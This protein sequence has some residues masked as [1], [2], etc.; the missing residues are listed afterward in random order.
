MKR[1]LFTA[2]ICHLTL[3]SLTGQQSAP[4]VGVAQPVVPVT[5]GFSAHPGDD[6]IRG[7]QLFQEMLTP[8][9]GPA[10]E[11]ENED[12]AAALLVFAERT[13]HEDISMFTAFMQQHPSSRWNAALLLNL[14]FERYER[15]YLTQALQYWENAWNLAKAETDEQRKLVADR[16]VGEILLLNAR[17][18]RVPVLEEYLAA[19]ELR[20]YDGSIGAQVDAARQGLAR[21][22]TQPE[23]AFKCGPYA[24]NSILN[25]Q[26][27]TPNAS[28]AQLEAVHSTSQGTNLLQVKNWAAEVG[29]NYQ[30]ARRGE[31]AAYVYPAVLHWKLDHFAALLGQ[32]DGRYLVQDATFNGAEMWI[33]EKALEAET[34][35]YYLIRSGPLPEGW[36]AVSDEQAAQI[37]GKGGASGRDDDAKNSCSS[38]TGNPTCQGGAG[39]AG[40]NYY[41]MHATLNI[42]DTPMYH[43]PP[44]GPA[45]DVSVNYN[46]LET[47]QPAIPAYANL[48]P[49]WDF[50][51]TGFVEV[52]ASLT[53]K[54]RLRH[55]GS[56]VYPLSL[57]NNITGTYW[58]NRYSQ[59]VLRWTTDP[60]GNDVYR[61]EFRDGSAE[62][63]SQP[64]SATNTPDRRYYLKQVLDAQGNGLTLN[65]EFMATASASPVYSNPPVP[66]QNLASATAT[67]PTGRVTEIVDAAGG[68]TLIRYLSNTRGHKGFFK[69]HRIYSPAP[70]DPVTGLPP[71]VEFEYDGTLAAPGRLKSIRDVVGMVS[72]FTYDAS[73]KAAD[74]IDSMTTEYGRTLFQQ[75]STDQAHTF[76]D[77]PD[78]DDEPDVVM[79][80]GLMRGLRITYPNSSVS[81]VENWL[82][83]DM[84]T[85]HWSR[86]AMK[87]HPMDVQL[88]VSDPQRAEH[89]EVYQW[90][91]DV[92]GRQLVPIIHSIKRPLKN[93]VTFS[94]DGESIVNP[95]DVGHSNVGDTNQPGEV[96][97][98]EEGE[99]G[100]A[101]QEQSA[102]YNLLGNLTEITDPLGRKTLLT[103]G[104]NGVDLLEVRQKRAGGAELLSR[105]QYNS[106]HLPTKVWDAGGHLTE[107]TYNSYGQVT[108]AKDA[109]GRIVTYAYA[110]AVGAVN[111]NAHDSLLQSIDGPL[112]G[113][114]DVTHFTYD[115]HQRL[116]SVTDPEGYTVWHE[117]DEL[118]RVT[119]VTYQPQ[120]VPLDQA[121]Y[122]EVVWDKLDPVLIRDRKGRITR[123]E[124]DEMGQLVVETDSE[125]RR[126]EYEWCIC[127]SLAK[128]KD[129]NGSV[130]EW[131]YDEIG[132]LTGK[133]RTDGRLESLTYY[134][135]SDRVRYVTVADQVRREFVYRIDGSIKKVAFQVNTAAAGQPPVFVDDPMTP[136]V[137]YQ[138]DSEHPRL[139]SASLLRGASLEDAISYDYHPYRSSATAPLLPGAGQVR[140]IIDAAASGEVHYSYDALGR[141]SRR[142]IDSVVNGSE[143]ESAQVL[144]TEFDEA[145]RVAAM[146]DPLGRFVYQYVD[147]AKGFSRLDQVTFPNGQVSRF[148]WLEAAGHHRLESI[149]HTHTP[150]GGAEAPV[151]AHHYGYGP[152]GRLTGWRQQT[153]LATSQLWQIDHDDADQ[154]R[155]VVVRDGQ[156]PQTILKQHHYGYDAGG[157]R[158]WWQEDL[159][160]RQVTHNAMNQIMARPAGGPVRFQGTLDEPGMLSITVDGQ[161]REAEMRTALD[162]TG[163]PEFEFR[164]DVPLNDGVNQVELKAR[165]GSGNMT[166][167]PRVV[168]VT[169]SGQEGADIPLYDARGNMI[170]DGKGRVFGW[171]ALNRLVRITYADGS[172]TV[173]HYDSLGRRAREVELNA[174]GAA[175][176]E[177]RLLWCG[178][179]LCQERDA[180]Y[181]VMK[182]W[183][184]HGWADSSQVPWRAFFVTRDHLG[185]VREVTNWD[186]LIV[187]RH[188]YGPYGE[189]EG[190][191]QAAQPP[192]EN[193]HL[194]LRADA[195]VSTD[196]QGKV[197]QWGREGVPEDDRKAISLSEESRPQWVKGVQD[198]AAVRFDGQDDAL[199]GDLGLDARKETLTIFAAHRAQSFPRGAVLSFSVPVEGAGGGE[200]TNPNGATALEWQTNTAPLAYGLAGAIGS[201]VAA[202][203]ASGGYLAEQWQV[204]TAVQQVSSSES[205]GVTTWHRHVELRNR[206]PDGT[207]NESTA[208]LPDESFTDTSEKYALG[209]SFV[210]V[211]EQ[212]VGRGNLQGDV[213]EVLIYRGELTVSQRQQIERY[214][215]QKYQEEFRS[216]LRYTGHYYHKKS[217]LHLA[218]YRAYDAK[219]AVWLSEDPLGEE[220]G[221]NL[222]GYVG[223]GPLMFTDP[224][225]LEWYDWWEY[226]PEPSTTQP[227][228]NFVEGLADSLSLGIGPLIKNNIEGYDDIKADRC[229]TSYK[230]GGWASFALGTGRLAYAGIAKVGSRL[231]ASG[232]QA[233]A[234]RTG[235]GNAFRFGAPRPYAPNLAKYP[236][237]DLLRAAAGRT[238]PLMNAYGAGAAA[239]G[240]YNGLGGPCP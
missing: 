90:L 194:W 136:A 139:L 83:H 214:L 181:R 27:R 129:G 213:G 209:R 89:C 30:V 32:Q 20:D 105:V 110:E 48:G 16:A 80:T 62:V 93:L 208:N 75:Y 122:E 97:T 84:K 169:V 1:F 42:R 201:G 2:T 55:G 191:E 186:G 107:M 88:P 175:Y 81:V 137:V 150:P 220:G 91:M 112:P 125:G 41:L 168:E 37:W 22:K 160:V 117:Y 176:A 215:S 94:Y 71:Y 202:T 43:V 146:T 35:G 206:R 19:L 26:A 227:V 204:S 178:L 131:H 133:K 5:L 210:A 46:H 128:L 79:V 86:T 127:G 205:G 172:A 165:D 85:Y 103:Y 231:A 108:S 87:H 17:L 100:P 7:C 162:P 6:E 10:Q 187:S 21:M 199:E 51:W 218:P 23:I 69:V 183:C 167:P 233:S 121:E 135:N 240:A 76:A 118:N 14:G 192:S 11:A 185:S 142:S 152:Q 111:P 212:M 106:L 98:V 47:G 116:E 66:G 173:F 72:K 238:N 73:A 60:Q 18:G 170:Q 226:M 40:A 38:P 216:N 177:K 65:Y 63:Y 197:M 9:S 234:F 58:P 56:E 78:A 34:D 13:D 57:F 156:T 101:T 195:G 230:V 109:L 15:G 130:T 104:G 190:E 144:E 157:N 207:V 147:A 203:V 158:K 25:L 188:S 198:H 96:V 132:R 119:R 196:A 120:G 44:V 189:Q 159:R 211:W 24:L 12:L 232:A 52:D 179:E 82:G 184:A 223:N 61:R 50:N 229:S 4:R 171:D 145:G 180:E 59:A 115:D 193:L 166:S 36:T 92:K 236:T 155:S 237:D 149:V 222:Y 154:L 64:L 123:R 102:D 114:E 221:L 28:C 239:A 174:S 45:V 138:Y 70:A 164:A 99:T 124:F 228:T 153:G 39:M 31:G 217:G 200:A 77:G 33:T 140:R 68:V 143:D 148:G 134:S 113:N 219:L 235:L 225:G 8:M 74:F 141:V 95:G 29:L 126:V 161:T 67:K 53:A 54:V 151:S 224:L 182:M 3:L 49:N 163:Q